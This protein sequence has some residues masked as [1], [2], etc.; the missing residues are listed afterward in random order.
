MYITVST[1]LSLSTVIDER[2]T[3]DEDAAIDVDCPHLLAR[4][5]SAVNLETLARDSRNAASCIRS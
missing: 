4:V 5:I 2:A 3:T 1:G